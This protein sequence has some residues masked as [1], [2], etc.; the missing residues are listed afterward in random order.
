MAFT[1]RGGRG[2]FAPRGGGGSFRGRGGGGDRG[3]R[4]ASRGQYISGILGFMPI[5]CVRIP[6]TYQRFQQVVEVAPEVAR[7]VGEEV[8]H[9]V[10][11]VE[12]AV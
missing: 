4:G 11:V 10:E 2:G 3:G 6:F 5:P 7:P 1:P 9:L 12:V 8:H